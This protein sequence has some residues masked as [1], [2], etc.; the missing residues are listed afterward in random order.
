MLQVCEQGMDATDGVVAELRREMVLGGQYVW[1]PLWGQG[2]PEAYTEVLFG[3]LDGV[4]EALQ[5]RKA[6]YGGERRLIEG[7]GSCWSNTGS[8][9]D[10]AEIEVDI[11]P[12]PLE[13]VVVAAIQ[14]GEEECAAVGLAGKREGNGELAQQPVGHPLW[15]QGSM[16]A[17]NEV[18]SG[19]LKDEVRALEQRKADY[20]EARGLPDGSGSCWSDSDGDSG[21]E[22]APELGTSRACLCTNPEF[23]LYP[24]REKLVEKTS[25][26]DILHPGDNVMVK[27]AAMLQVAV[28]RSPRTRINEF[29][30]RHNCH[31]GHFI[32]CRQQS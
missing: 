9:P 29:V 30:I 27:G 26:I 19:H 24:G 13:G 11:E 22:T 21:N 32:E 14:D 20:D 12:I 16:R 4:V 3:N 31:K 10:S 6:V 2:P 8:D 25:E 7:S 5:Q 28:R 18:L 17:L 15:G 23:P 1:H